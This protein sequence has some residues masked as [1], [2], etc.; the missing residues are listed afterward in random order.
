MSKDKKS[1]NPEGMLIRFRKWW[2]GQA[3]IDDSP[4]PPPPLV[5]EV[6]REEVKRRIVK[7]DYLRAEDTNCP[8]ELYGCP[9]GFIEYREDYKTF[10]DNGDVEDDMIF[11][12]SMPHRAYRYIKECTRCGWR[13][14]NL[15]EHILKFH[16]DNCV[17]G[18]R[19]A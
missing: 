3:V 18:W 1:S 14:E 15:D 11:R 4:S 12:Y 7:R 6:K 2:E 8:F 13:T 17:E 10:Y 19:Y 5:E 16:E 9:T